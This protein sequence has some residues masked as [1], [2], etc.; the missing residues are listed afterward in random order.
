MAFLRCMFQTAWVITNY[1]LVRLCLVPFLVF[2]ALLVGHSD[3]LLVVRCV[4][5]LVVGDYFL[6][7]FFFRFQCN[8]K[9]FFHVLF[10]VIT[11][12]V[13]KHNAMCFCC[14]NASQFFH[15]LTVPM[16]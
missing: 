13:V 5:I 12:P 7:N 15:L 2:S 6:I 16:V 14:F 3:F 11:S 9:F 4:E 1:C 10:V 8:P